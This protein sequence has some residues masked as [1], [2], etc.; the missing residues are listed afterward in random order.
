MTKKIWR[1]LC[2]FSVFLAGILL[3]EGGVFGF[4][5][6][7]KEGGAFDLLCGRMCRSVLSGGI[8][9]VR[10]RAGRNKS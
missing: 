4:P 6:S 8:S 7:G 10:K 2:S 1:L 3:Y 5:L 9:K